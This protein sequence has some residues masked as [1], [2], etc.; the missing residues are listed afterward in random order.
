MILI[1]PLLNVIL[2]ILL[3]GWITS[4]QKRPSLLATTSGGYRGHNA[5]PLLGWAAWTCR[6]W[7]LAVEWH[8]PVPG[9]ATAKHR[10]L[11]R[12]EGGREC[13]WQAKAGFDK[14]TSLET[15]LKR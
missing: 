8:Q 3:A 7:R 12:R 11:Q 9:T 4:L 5:V 10:V 15:S 14:E 6:C 2:T 13:S 1:K